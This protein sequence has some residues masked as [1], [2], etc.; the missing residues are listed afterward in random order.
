M[1]RWL[2]GLL[3]GLSY[4]GTPL[5]SLRGCC[6]EKNAAGLHLPPSFHLRRESTKVQQGRRKGERKGS[7]VPKGQG[8]WHGAY[9]TNAFGPIYR[10]ILEG[11]TAR[12]GLFL[13]AQAVT[14][15]RQNPGKYNFKLGNLKALLFLLAWQPALFIPSFYKLQIIAL[16]SCG[17]REFICSALFW[18]NWGIQAC[19]RLQSSGR[20][21]RCSGTGTPFQCLSLGSIGVR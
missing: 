18:L 11:V 4:V 20:Y 9:P 15:G 1:L 8:P 13:R 12:L 21:W 19:K 6:T 3:Y 7:G 2:L 10:K 14:Q 5:H 17:A 16:Y